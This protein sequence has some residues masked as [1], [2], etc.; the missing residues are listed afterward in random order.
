VRDD[1]FS[2][3][4]SVAALCRRGA[5]IAAFT[6]ALLLAGSGPAAAH[7]EVASD[8]PAQAGTGPVTLLFMAEAESRT[9]GIVS[10]K[11]QLPAGMAPAD[12]SLVSA[13]E[14]WVLTPTADGFELG[15]PAVAPGLDAEYSVAVAHLPADRTELAFPTLQR[16]SDGTEDAWIEPV[17]EAAPEPEKPAPV[18]T[19][20]PA[21]PGATTTPAPSETAAPPTTDSG[22]DTAAPAEASERSEQ[23]SN[24]GTLVLVVALVAAVAIGAGAWI[25]RARRRA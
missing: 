4:H 16:Y 19:V 21:P 10:V 9:A 13:P 1:Y 20:A 7:I 24:T 3:D 2:V 17:T 18:L 25:W 5:L 8:G 12:V 23:D 6:T 11:T 15:G 14:G 22:A